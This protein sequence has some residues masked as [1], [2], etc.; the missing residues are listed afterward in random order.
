MAKLV[1]K[2]GTHILEA[3]YSAWTNRAKIKLDGVELLSKLA[4]TG[5]TEVMEVDNK[6][7]LVKFGGLFLPNI[8]IEE[9]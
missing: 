6:K 2:I 3:E 4:W 1:K 7:Y 9:L 5:H 8:S